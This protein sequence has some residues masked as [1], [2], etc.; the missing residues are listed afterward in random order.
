[1][2]IKLLDSASNLFQELPSLYTVH[3]T[4]FKLEFMN[5]RNC[6]ILILLISFFSITNCTIQGQPDQTAQTVSYENELPTR[7]QLAQNFWQQDKPHAIL[8]HPS[9]KMENGFKIISKK[10][11][12]MSKN[13][14]TLSIKCERNV[15]PKD[16]ENQAVIAI[17]S[18]KSN[19]II[20]GC[21]TKLPFH[22]D[23]KKI[24][25][26]NL[27]YSNKET[28]AMLPF[29]PNPLSPTM[30]MM[31]ISGLDNESIFNFLNEKIKNEW[32]LF[33]WG[34]WG[35][36]VY[37]NSRRVLLG[38][39]DDQTWAMNEKV[40]FEFKK[41]PE[42]VLETP[43]FRFISDY[44]VS[45]KQLSELSALSEK[46]I[47]RILSFTNTQKSIPKCN[48][49]LYPTTE[50]KGL[51][52]HN[53]EHSHVNFQNIEIHT[54]LNDTYQDNY[55]GKENELVVRQLLGKPKTVALERGLGIY[56]TKKW[57]KKGWEYWAKKLYKTDN[58]LPLSEILNEDILNQGS[59]LLTGCLAASF[60]D[61]LIETFG[62]ST[63]LEGYQTWS[64]D[65][66]EILHLEK[67]WHQYLDEK[68]DA[69][70]DHD[71]T[72]SRPK[73]KMPYLKGFNFA[74]EGYRIYNGYGSKKATESLEKLTGLGT[75][76]IAIVPYGYMNN[77]QTPSFI[78]M[79]NRPGSE[80]DE[81]VIHSFTMAKKMGMS[82]MLKPQ[83]WFR[84]SWPGD[85]EMNSEEE[86]HQFFHHY[87]HWIIHYAMLAEI[88]NMPM[89]CL[90]VEFAKATVQRSDDWKKL[91]KQTRGIYAGQLT[92]AANWGDEFENIDF[93][94]ELDFIGL[95]CYYPL[96]HSEECSK[97]ELKNGFEKVIDKI[98][99]VVKKHKKPLVF[100]EIGF[101]SINAPWK[102][103]HAGQRNDSF[104][105]EHQKK[106]YEAVFES[107]K[108]QKW[109][110]GIL[111]WKFPCYLDYR[112]L[113][114]GSFTP[115]NKPAEEIVKEWFLKLAE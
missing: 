115:N 87:H 101:R 19:K 25:I 46:A 114:N 89:F 75:N 63:F 33:G 90:G 49:F 27:E 53:T 20:S 86:W 6:P 28:V 2:T 52:L 105:G 74:H 1:M 23:S 109:C 41:E 65:E 43:H 103:P 72:K 71:Q 26:G 110:K 61:F 113:E 31:F 4:Y 34:N 56:F 58:L 30:P 15:T 36:E 66:S 106:C 92:Y 76:S 82:A 80:T 99:S 98:E 108:D 69:S 37:E 14:L 64:P 97:E 48:H 17:G 21:M 35:Y 91:I 12:E 104:N 18:P 47:Q 3:L 94:E 57:Q 39:F 67:Q 96:H 5:I 29:Y 111:W 107:V 112:G 44:N 32:N 95:N 40:H 77:T 62:Q 59:R 38:F 45:Q 9:G 79:S 78:R 51:I 85:V 102:E 50:Q 73:S 83:I 54:V 100:T 93:W 81:S 13:Y 84:G 24:Q 68:L 16:F 88:Y 10:M 7:R 55:I 11:V 70:S 42:T 8:V 22:I 60:T